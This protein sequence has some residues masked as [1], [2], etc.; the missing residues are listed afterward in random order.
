MARAS[1]DGPP[2]AVGDRDAVEVD[3]DGV[4]RAI[5]KIVSFVSFV[6][7][8]PRKERVGGEV[9]LEQVGVVGDFVE[10]ILYNKRVDGKSVIVTRA[11]GRF[12]A[13]SNICTHQGFTI[14]PGTTDGVTILCPVHTAIFDINTGECI[15]GPADDPLTLYTVRL[16]G[17]SVLVGEAE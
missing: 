17:D 2:L 15:E 4:A 6:L 13:L 8:S 16:E 1:A 3:D 11:N 7:P 10:G 12:Y 14:T 5:D 9:S